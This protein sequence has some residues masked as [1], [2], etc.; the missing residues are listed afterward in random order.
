MKDECF[1]IVIWFGCSFIYLPWVG[2]EQTKVIKTLFVCCLKTCTNLFHATVPVYRILAIPKV[3]S[4]TTSAFFGGF[5]FC[6]CC[7]HGRIVWREAHQCLLGWFKVAH[8]LHLVKSY[9]E[10]L[11]SLLFQKSLLCT[12]PVVILHWSSTA[13]VH[14]HTCTCTL[15]MCL[16]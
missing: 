2:W 12:N 4:K 7:Q 8:S 1:T 10:T 11:I 14:I 9:H 16:H 15:Y 13:F 6:C 5:F 3:Q